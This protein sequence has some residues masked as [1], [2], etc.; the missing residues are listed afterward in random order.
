[1]A[2]MQPLPKVVGTHIAIGPYRTFYACVP[3]IV[4]GSTLFHDNIPTS[5]RV[6]LEEQRTEPGRRFTSQVSLGYGEAWFVL[7]PNG[8]IRW[9]LNGHYNELEEILNEVPDRCVT[10]L[11]LN[12]WSAGQFFL[13]LED[14]TV[15]FCLPAEWAPGIMSDVAA[16]QNRFKTV[17]SS[18]IWGG[19]AESS[20]RVAGGGEDAPLTPQ[21]QVENAQGEQTGDLPPPYEGAH[22]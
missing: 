22:E 20:T 12:P 16:W 3:T 7:W 14:G 2:W 19:K 21:S 13:V 4:A 17:T 9:E 8:D 18:R 5:L 6:M 1:M 15:R 11:A 10:Y